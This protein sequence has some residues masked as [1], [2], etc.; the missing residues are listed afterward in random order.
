M[1]VSK[2]A[3]ICVTPN[4]KHKI[5]VTPNAKPQH[6]PMEYR[7]RWFPKAKFLRWPCSFHVVCAHFVCVGYLTRAYEPSLQWNMG[8]TVMNDNTQ[9]STIC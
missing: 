6:E 3:K 9:R 2:N 7:L 4:E 5:C 8:L 1:L